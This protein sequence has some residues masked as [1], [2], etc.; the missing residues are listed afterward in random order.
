[1]DVSKVIVQ[2]H[3]DTEL[4][5]AST[6]MTRTL[7]GQREQYLHKICPIGCQARSQTLLSCALATSACGP[8]CLFQ[9]PK[10]N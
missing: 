9:T 6:A 1:M 5:T 10:N 8:S 2:M 4:R 3:E 7:D